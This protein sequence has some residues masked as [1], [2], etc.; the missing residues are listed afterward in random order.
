MELFQHI[1]EQQFG[2]D[3]IQL[4]MELLQD[5]GMELCQKFLIVFQQL[6]TEFYG[7]ILQYMMNYF[8]K[9]GYGP[10]YELETN[11]VDTMNDSKRT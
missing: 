6:F 11:F 4:L 8:K 9:Q 1:I 5:I 7:H 2:Q 3:M 10:I